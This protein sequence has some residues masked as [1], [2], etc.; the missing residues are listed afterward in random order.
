MAGIFLVVGWIMLFAAGGRPRGPEVMKVVVV[1]V[2]SWSC[3]T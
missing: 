2:V 3:E 1:V